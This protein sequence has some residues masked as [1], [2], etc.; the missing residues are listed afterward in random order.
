VNHARRDLCGGCAAMRIPTA[1]RFADPAASVT[2]EWPTNRP[3]ALQRNLRLRGSW[4]MECRL[5][6]LLS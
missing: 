6:Q 5:A 3:Q 1:I 2:S 4:K